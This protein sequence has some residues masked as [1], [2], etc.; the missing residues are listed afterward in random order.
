MLRRLT[1][2]ELQQWNDAID[3]Y[4]HKVDFGKVM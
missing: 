4:Q 2:K 1:E 3:E